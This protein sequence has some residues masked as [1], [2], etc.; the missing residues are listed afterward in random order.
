M[1]WMQWCCTAQEVFFRNLIL[2]RGLKVSTDISSFQ[3]HELIEWISCDCKN[4]WMRHDHR[5]IVYDCWSVFEWQFSHVMCINSHAPNSCIVVEH[6][7][8]R[9]PLTQLSMISIDGNYL[10][11]C[12]Q[13][14]LIVVKPVSP[15]QYNDRLH[16]GGTLDST[17]TWAVCSISKQVVPAFES[18]SLWVGVWHLEATYAGFAN[19]VATRPYNV[20]SCG[21]PSLS[22]GDTIRCMS[23]YLKYWQ[24]T[25]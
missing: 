20:V 21:L 5:D 17:D 24:R 4:T 22:F 18:I 13:I 23:L 15:S 9:W 12:Q 8:W 7:N 2:Y 6:S 11:S 19:L 3:L 14:L 25:P 16:F 10:C 1:K